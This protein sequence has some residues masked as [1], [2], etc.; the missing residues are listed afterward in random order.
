MLVKGWAI[1]RL[2]PEDG[3]RPYGVLT[4]PKRFSAVKAALN[5]NYQVDLHSGFA[6]LDGH[7]WD[8]LFARSQVSR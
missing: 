8:K 1:A 5:G 2:Y 7:T 3:L 6:K 4:C